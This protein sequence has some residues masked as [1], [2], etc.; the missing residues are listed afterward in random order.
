MIA[1]KIVSD[2]MPIGQR[3]FLIGATLAI[4][5]IGPIAAGTFLVPVI[6]I[7]G[8]RGTLV[9]I[10]FVGLILLLL[11]FFGVTESKVKDEKFTAQDYKNILKE[12]VI[13]VSDKRVLYYSILAVGLYAPFSGFADFW[14]TNFLMQKY[15]LPHKDASQI[16]TMLYFGLGLGCLVF[17][18]LAEKTNSTNWMIKFTLAGLSISF[19]F[20]LYG[21]ALKHYQIMGALFLI[22]MFSGGEMICF[23]GACLNTKPENSGLTIGIVNTFNMLGAPLAQNIV[24]NVLDFRWNGEVGSNGLRLYTVEETTFAMSFLIYMIVFCIALAFWIRRSSKS[25]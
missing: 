19:A 16:Y 15:S 17:P 8:W 14:A 4:G 20:L 3:G 24:G 18:F 23:T 5:S 22:G 1:I 21:P 6:E 11:T 13:I 2:Y 7:Y 25:F 10:D 9:F 12:V